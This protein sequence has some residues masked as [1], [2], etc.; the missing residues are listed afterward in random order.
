M[1]EGRVRALFEANR[2]PIQTILH[3]IRMAGSPS[4]NTPEGP[5]QEAPTI[6]MM[7]AI[8]K[9]MAATIVTIVAIVPPPVA[10]ITPPVAVIA[11]AVAVIVN[12][13][14]IIATDG[15][16]IAPDGAVIASVAAAFKYGCSCDTTQFT[17]GRKELQ[18]L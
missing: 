3:R 8:I 6:E 5:R 13:V 7:A 14:A 10:I 16:K 9:A 11:T 12:P 4:T 15:A 2:P 17:Y 18:L 1:P